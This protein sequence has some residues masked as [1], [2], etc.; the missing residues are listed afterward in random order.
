[1]IDRCDDNIAGWS[2]QGD[3]FV[4]KNVDQFAAVSGVRQILLWQAKQ[5]IPTHTVG[6][7]LGLYDRAYFHSISSTATFPRLQGS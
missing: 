6:F 3:S 4:V 1:M 2:D 5:S 7:S